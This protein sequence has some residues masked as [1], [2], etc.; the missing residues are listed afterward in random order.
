M[1]NEKISELLRKREFVSVSTCDLEGRPNAAPKFIL[2]VS[3][4]FIYLIDYT[5]GR[6]WSN[7]KANPRASVSFMDTDSL[8]GYQINGKAQI[9]DGG[10]EYEKIGAEL[11][12]REIDL[13]ARRIIEGV[14]RE[15]RHAGFEVGLSEKFVLLKIH[16]EEIV[17]IGLRGE[18][19]REHIQGELC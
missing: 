6:T 4:N 16:I 1:L 14:G 13:S 17:E 11:L 10:A 7:L 8:S 12:Q 18:V 2:K 15:K 19:K 9:I 5:I 3:G